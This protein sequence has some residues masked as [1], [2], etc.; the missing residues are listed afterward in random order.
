MRLFGRILVCL[1]VC[2]W[3]WGNTKAW[4]QAVE[5]YE[6]RFTPVLDL[7]GA[8]KPYFLDN[9][10]YYWLSYAERM[11][12]NGE[13]RI[14]STNID[15][16]PY[17]REMHWSQSMA[18]LEVG[19]G[20]IRSLVTGESWL[21]AIPKAAIWI[22]PTLFA[23][24]LCLFFC[25][26]EGAWGFLPAGLALLWMVSHG[27]L[28]WG[29]HSYRPDHQSLH[30]MFSLLTFLLLSLGGVGW[31]SNS[32]ID[33]EFRWIR[34]VAPPPDKVARRYFIASGIVGGLGLWIGATV[35]I[36]CLGL[37]M[38]GA[39]SAAFLFRGK[40]PEKNLRFTPQLYRLWARVGAG[41]S[42]LMYAIEY[43][44]GWP[45]LRLE[46]NHPLYAIAWLA[47]GEAMALFFGACL[48]RRFFTKKEWVWAGIFALFALALPATLFFGGANVHA[49]KD[50]EMFRLHE[51][52]DEFQNY[53]ELYKGS[54]LSNFFGDHLILPILLPAALSFV[55]FTKLKE[56]ERW[57]IWMSFCVC[58]G[59][60]ILSVFQQ[61]W[62]AYYAEFSIMLMA[63]IL[64]VGIR[65]VDKSMRDFVLVGTSLILVA[66]SA[67]LSGKEREKLIQLTEG[68]AIIDQ[69]VHPILFK[70]FAVELAEI[71][72]G[73][74]DIRLMVDPA[75][76]PSLYYFARFPST[77]TFYWENRD[78]LHAATD[79]FDAS[80]DERAREIVR[81]RGITHV[82]MSS[83]GHV[84]ET[85][86]YIRS[87]SFPG[88]DYT[89]LASR[90]MADRDLPDWLSLDYDALGLEVESVGF[91]PGRITSQI[92]IWKVTSGQSN[93]ESGR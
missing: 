33:R 76:A 34:L 20:K 26:V 56:V 16:V 61:R 89:N 68:Q 35:E 45:R 21:E 72:K 40:P 60:L 46:V 64:C 79:F 30:L 63:L 75:L 86:H 51:F 29:F 24:F 67:V 36:L 7:P 48:E 73:R 55:F 41:T 31:V 93:T 9:D 78:G 47:M 22:N 54:L 14:R 91:G 2:V 83:R 52:I 12:T 87:G 25:L 28:A 37:M 13:W 69:A 6:A 43:M 50:P 15:N 90:L 5:S 23:I 1:S 70:R 65:I 57:T 39:V 92:K 84:P 81:E 11:V 38:A 62:F 59:V 82:I 71:F 80:S 19:F 44:P 42:L 66:G 32:P 18:W 10:C 88:T 27:D 58:A 77:V 4:R 17:G 85:F 53:L 49:M 3:L 74:E 8:K